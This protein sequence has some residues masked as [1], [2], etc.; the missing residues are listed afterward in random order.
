MTRRAALGDGLEVGARVAWM[1]GFNFGRDVRRV[2]G[3][4]VKVGLGIP[5]YEQQGEVGAP[6]YRLVETHRKPA[7]E[8]LADGHTPQVHEA[9]N[10]VAVEDLEI[11]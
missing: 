3:V 8:V 6:S 10:I 2:E 5:V 7:V 11:L 9:P 1:G 4:V